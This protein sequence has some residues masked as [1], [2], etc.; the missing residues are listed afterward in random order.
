MRHFVF[1]R[2]KGPNISCVPNNFERE[3]LCCVLLQPTNE[4]LAI[5]FVFGAKRQSYGEDS[6][7]VKE[8]LGDDVVVVCTWCRVEISDDSIDESAWEANID[9]L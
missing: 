8:P 1:Q 7:I 4:Y 5:F 3:F 9:V 6:L 2:K